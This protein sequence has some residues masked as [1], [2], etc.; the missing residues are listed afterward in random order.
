SFP[1]PIAPQQTLPLEPKPFKHPQR[2][3]IVWMCQRL[4]SLH[5]HLSK[6]PVDEQPQRTCRHS[7][8][9]GL[10]SEQVPDLSQPWVL[11]VRS[12]HVARATHNTRPGIDDGQRERTTCLSGFLGT[13]V[14]RE[15]RFL[16]S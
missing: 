4:D 15:D 1:R 9:A 3:R 5:P 10:L 14:P 7:T 6:A 8:T 2:A 11:R 13:R 16:R 12:S